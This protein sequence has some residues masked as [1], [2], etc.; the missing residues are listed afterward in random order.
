M[1]PV[2]GDDAFLH[3]NLGA[4]GEVYKHTVEPLGQDPPPDD[5]FHPLEFLGTRERLPVGSLRRQKRR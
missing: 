4:V 5:P 1:G 3:I 2:Y